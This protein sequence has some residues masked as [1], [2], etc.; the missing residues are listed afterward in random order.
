M[1]PPTPST[2]PRTTLVVEEEV[3]FVS[4]AFVVVLALSSDT[5][6]V[7]ASA[8]LVVV[9]VVPG[10]DADIPV[11]EMILPYWSTSAFVML[12]NALAAKAAVPFALKGSKL[13]WLVKARS[14]FQPPSLPSIVT[15]Q[16]YTVVSKRLNVLVISCYAGSLFCL[17]A[18]PSRRSGTYLSLGD[19]LSP[20]DLSR[21]D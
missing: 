19:S 16:L 7:L 1:K 6:V 14:K 21:P 10:K 2:A 9:E 4:T 17:V 5:T 12:K 18:F 20:S 13:N 8:R 3:S 15:F 11:V